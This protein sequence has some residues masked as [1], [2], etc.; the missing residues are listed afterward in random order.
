M[1]NCHYFTNYLF[2]FFRRKDSRSGYPF[3]NDLAKSHIFVTEVKSYSSSEKV[4]FNALS[5][6]R[7]LSRL[8]SVVAPVAHQGFCVVRML[9]EDFVVAVCRSRA[10]VP[11]FFSVLSYFAIL[12]E[13]ILASA[14]FFRIKKLGLMS[15]NTVSFA[16]VR[17]SLLQ[18]LSGFY[19]PCAV[20]DVSLPRL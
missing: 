4:S 13:K 16:C 3:L 8:S 12:P 17:I 14:S 6:P 9:S 11:S 18:K 5:A 19:L 20:K 2:L 15:F 7:V 10:I 1:L